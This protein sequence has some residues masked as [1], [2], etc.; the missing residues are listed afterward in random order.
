MKSIVHRNT[1]R[2]LPRRRSNGTGHHHRCMNMSLAATTTITMII[3][4]VVVG[5][6]CA[7]ERIEQRVVGVLNQHRRV[8]FRG[9]SN[10]RTLSKRPVPEYN[11]IPQ[12]ITSTRQSKTGDFTRNAPGYLLDPA[13]FSN[14]RSNGRR[15]EPSRRSAL[16]S[17]EAGLRHECMRGGLCPASSRCAPEQSMPNAAARTPLF[18]VVQL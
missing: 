4:I 3:I 18:M 12:T 13:H 8:Q 16:P 6:V 9:T 17:V 7:R 5:A 15:A 2:W 11:I 10:T 1:P 14:E